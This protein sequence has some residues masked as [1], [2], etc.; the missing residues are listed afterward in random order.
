[1][2]ILIISH[3]SNITLIQC[4]INIQAGEPIQML[5]NKIEVVDLIPDTVDITK[6]AAHCYLNI[7]YE[8]LK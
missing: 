8:A 6:L 5:H 7:L 3:T 1:M 2:H 4:A